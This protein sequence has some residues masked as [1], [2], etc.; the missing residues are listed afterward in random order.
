MSGDRFGSPRLTGPFETPRLAARLLR[1]QEGGR[2]LSVLRFFGVK[3][4]AVDCR[5]CGSSGSKSWGHI[6][7][8]VCKAQEGQGHFDP[9][10]RCEERARVRGPV[11]LPT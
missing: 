8:P 3:R 1:D 6:L 11:T 7:I 9:E 10:G 5:C 4:V 2:Q